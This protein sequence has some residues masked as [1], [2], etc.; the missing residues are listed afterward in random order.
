MTEAKGENTDDVSGSVL[1][2]NE[3]DSIH[4]SSS[5]KKMTNQEQL[6]WN[7]LDTIFDIKTKVFKNKERLAL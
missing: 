1:P 3:I 6:F 7:L 5:K 2:A 4:W